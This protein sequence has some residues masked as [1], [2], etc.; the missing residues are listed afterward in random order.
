VNA[1]RTRELFLITGGG[2]QAEAR[3]ASKP[4][5]A[6]V[7]GHAMRV[8]LAFGTR[9]EIVKL[10]PVVQALKRIPGVKLD[11]FWTGQHI[12]LA[13]GLL[14]LFDIEVTH[15]GSDIIGQSGLAGKFG[16][17]AQQIESVLQ[18]NRYDWV[19]VQG[20]TATA[21]AAATAGFLNHVPVAHVEAGLR[22][23][24]LYSPWPEEF[25]RRTI[26]MCSALHFA[27]T[28][29]A[30]RNLLAEGVPAD[31]VLVVGNTVVDALLRVR[32]KIKGRYQPIDPAVAELPQDKKLVLATLHRRENIGRAMRQVLSALRELGA[33]GD[34]LIVLPVHLNPQVRSQVIE[35]LGDAPNVRLLKPLQYPD[36]VYLL[37]KAWVVV[38]DSGGVQEEAPT[39]GLPVLI[40]R[41][42]TER[43]EV[44]E[45]GFG[46]LVG[47]DAVAIVRS[48]RA[49][50]Q[51]D[52]P[53]RLPGQ[54]PFGRGDSAVQIAERL[55]Q[56]DQS[57]EVLPHA[58][59]A[60][61]AGRG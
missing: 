48:V 56:A 17:M 12:E 52:R 25:N 30:A 4:P 45:A 28:A 15:T 11:V 37:S 3:E 46:Q 10:G 51:S 40:T 59:A 60:R 55:A 27:P 6:R 31:R 7:D 21:A 39:F 35:T 22:T 19:L 2:P 38:T 29:A 1:E 26:T 8:L 44:I 34:K 57:E 20:D 24:D 42:T 54:N 49:L 14:Q 53:Q 50:T 47:S 43:P 9:P 23:G 16:L 32:A 18:K 36:F 5:H 33:D 58:R 61:S 13:A 41:D